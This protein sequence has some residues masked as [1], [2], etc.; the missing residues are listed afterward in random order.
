MYSGLLRELQRVK[1]END[2][3]G[4]IDMGNGVKLQRRFSAFPAS[5]FFWFY[6]RWLCWHMSVDS[7][8][9]AL[10]KR[11]E[12]LGGEI[13][14]LSKKP[15]ATTGNAIIVFNWVHNAANMLY[16]H[17]LRNR[18]SLRTCDEVAVFA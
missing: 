7:T 15:D 9:E 6:K 16:D 13:M 2:D 1:Q 14:D 4:E 17:N 12:K 3:V 5:I 18:C 10:E 11:D 8:I